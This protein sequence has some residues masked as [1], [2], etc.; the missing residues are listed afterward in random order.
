MAVIFFRRDPNMQLWK[1]KTRHFLP[2]YCISMMKG[3]VTH[4][5]ELDGFSTDQPTFIWSSILM[6]LHVNVYRRFALLTLSR[7]TKGRPGKPMG[8][9]M[10]LNGFGPF[11]FFSGM[12]LAIDAVPHGGAKCTYSRRPCVKSSSKILHCA[13]EFKSICNIGIPLTAW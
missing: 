10:L 5:R 7:D 4:I 13:G 8:C 11:R 2:R 9:F 12:H 3:V 6:Y 1:Q